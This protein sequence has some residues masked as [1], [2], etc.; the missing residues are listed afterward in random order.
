MK[1]GEMKISDYVLDFVSWR[2]R[3]AYNTIEEQFSYYVRSKDDLKLLKFWAT[4]IVSDVKTIID[5]TEAYDAIQR[6]EH[7]KTQKESLFN[8]LVCGMINDDQF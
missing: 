6:A 7:N 8:S 1:P 2:G 3:N 4:R 5:I